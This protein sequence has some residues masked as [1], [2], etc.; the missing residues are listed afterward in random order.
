MQRSQTQ[1]LS[2]KTPRGGRMTAGSDSSEYIEA[3]SPST[4][5]QLTKE[6]FTDIRTGKG[7]FLIYE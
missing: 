2:K 6:D 1:P 5:C 3:L 4:Q 7:H